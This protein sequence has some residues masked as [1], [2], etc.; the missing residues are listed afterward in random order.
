MREHPH[1]YCISFPDRNSVLNNNDINN[2]KTTDLTCRKLKLQGHVTAVN[3]I[4]I[5]IILNFIKS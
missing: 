2:N 1:N 3:L 4:I 5:F